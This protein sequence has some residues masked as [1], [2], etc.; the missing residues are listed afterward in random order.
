M[1]IIDQIKNGIMINTGIT[2]DIKDGSIEIVTKSINTQKYSVIDYIDLSEGQYTWYTS[3]FNDPCR[4]RQLAGALLIKHEY[5][6]CGDFIYEKIRDVYIQYIS[7]LCYILNGYIPYIP[8]LCID[9]ILEK[10]F[11]DGNLHYM[12]FNNNWCSTYYEYGTVSHDD[13]R[14]SFILLPAASDTA[15]SIYKIT[16]NEKPIGIII[17]R[18]N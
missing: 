18:V 4:G 3:N 13:E 11:V 9:D 5:N 2:F 15:L 16:Q 8:H 6:I 7:D 12:L 17:S 1:N 10:S 14:K